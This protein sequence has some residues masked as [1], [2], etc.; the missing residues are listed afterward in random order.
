MSRLK[1]TRI[2]S[3]AGGDVVLTHA[4]RNAKFI[5]FE[6][7]GQKM[8]FETGKIGRQADGAVVAR[9]A[10]TIVH[11]TVCYDKE[12]TKLDFSPLRV[13]YFARFSAVG[14]TSGSY[15]KRDSRGNDNEIL[16]ARLV[17]RSIRSV[18]PEGWRHDTQLI[19]WVLSYDKK[20]SPEPLAICAASA[21]LAL[22][23]IPMKRPIAGVEV[24]LINN[25]F[26]VNPTTDAK[27]K[28]KLSLI[29][30]GTEEGIVM[31]EGTANFLTEIEFLE[32][33]R[34]GH[35]AIR[36]ICKK[37]D[38]FAQRYGKTKRRDTLY[39]APSS[40]LADM[41][42]R[43]GEQMT[44]ALSIGHKLQRGKAVAQVKQQI[45]QHFIGVVRFNND[46]FVHT[47]DS[48]LE[49]S[50]LKEINSPLP[51]DE[52][53]VIASSPELRG[54]SEE[55]EASEILC[56]SSLRSRITPRKA[57]AYSLEDVQVAIKKLMGLRLRGKILNTGKRSDGRGLR[58]IRPIDIE[59]SWLPGAHGSVLF[60]RGE[61][62]S[63]CTATIGG[64]A[65]E[66]STDTLDGTQQ[67][68][69]YVQYRFPPSANGEI[70][71]GGGNA[72]SRRE[73]GHGNLAER[74]LASSLPDS[75]SFPYCIRGESLVTE[76]S[77]SSSMATVCGLNLAML[78]A[79][80]PLTKQ[81]AGIAMGLI[82]PDDTF[83][84]TQEPAILS[85][86]IGL[87]DAFGAMDLK[88]A[89][90]ENSLTAFQL[91]IKSS[92]GL[93]LNLL[94]K[95][96]QQAQLGRQQILQV[97]R[98]HL[99]S[100]RSLNS[101]VQRIK[102]F[103][104]PPDSIGKIIGPKGRTVQSLVDAFNVQDIRLDND[105]TV[106]ISGGT[107]ESIEQVKASIMKMLRE[108]FFSLDSTKR[109]SAIPFPSH[110]GNYSQSRK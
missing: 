78:D 8:S 91:D 100:P 88:V 38:A 76:S 86:I 3:S 48:E 50:L 16:T 27:K 12:T 51:D 90:D 28:S 4:N 56:R 57:T 67:R 32:A 52:D 61:T 85:D 30:A 99:S 62:Q 41:N 79:G 11:S 26:V 106:Q 101:Q 39:S 21:T 1:S 31:I 17:D 59:S 89:G 68:R 33:V 23:E 42:L 110:Y 104:V 40:L 69:F 66:M 13:D 80:V 95:V 10:D 103:V 34:V 24:S 18:I 96:L 97:M 107:D 9:M 102:T 70:A 58:D 71:R 82:L 7:A 5:E 75:V 60:T 74:A 81:V 54:I 63:I 73:V 20:H 37:I 55:D 108:D 43:F 47:S 15:T 6:V 65:M 46:S 94:G 49:E 22:S 77:G 25:A 29:M 36:E 45:E 92:D 84:H 109:P 87:E 105:G 2:K 98:N 19:S 53:D 93:T 83:N 14:Q 64:K 44:E 72:I 35:S